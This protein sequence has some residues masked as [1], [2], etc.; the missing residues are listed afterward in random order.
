MWNQEVLPLP[1]GLSKKAWII[2]INQTN[3][4]GRGN[5][6]GC[7]NIKGRD[8]S[9]SIATHCQLLAWETFFCY[10]SW[11]TL[12]NFFVVPSIYTNGCWL[13][14]NSVFSSF[15]MCWSNNRK[16]TEKCT[17]WTNQSSLIP[18]QPPSVFT[19]C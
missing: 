7:L 17:Q 1:I 8:K 15:T 6:F 5:L 18:F 19:M 10:A 12:F 4:D 11:E 13:N 9:P 2:V 3:P 14:I 16:T